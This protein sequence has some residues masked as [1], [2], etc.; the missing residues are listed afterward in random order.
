MRR[1]RQAVSIAAVLVLL[2]SFDTLSDFQVFSVWIFYGLTGVSVFVLRRML[3]DAERPYRVFGYPVV[4][5]IFVA[6][7]VWL[8]YE[9]V[10]GAPVRSLIGLGII[11][12][13]LPVYAVLRRSANARAH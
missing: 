6:A 3:P 11:A 5:A 13:A 7:T 12:L 2:G 10:V 8:L 9:A 4:P 1:S